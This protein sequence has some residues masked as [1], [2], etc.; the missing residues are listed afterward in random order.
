MITYEE[1]KERVRRAAGDYRTI[2]KDYVL[3][4]ATAKTSRDELVQKLQDIVSPLSLPPIQ[5][6]YNG[7]K[8]YI[9]I[10]VG[11]GEN[12]MYY[13]ISDRSATE[14]NAC[15]KLR[16]TIEDTLIRTIGRT[17]GRY[18]DELGLK[19]AQ[20]LYSY[21]I[22]VMN[23]ITQDVLTS[24]IEIGKK[25]YIDNQT[26][27]NLGHKY[28]KY[29][30]QLSLEMEAAANLWLSQVAIVPGMKLSIRDL[31]VV[32][33]SGKTEVRTVKRVADTT[34]AIYFRETT[35]VVTD[36]TRI[37][38]LESW[39]INEPEFAE[40]ERVLNLLNNIIR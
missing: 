35:S 1:A 6:Q 9:T 7:D 38:A 13:S 12:E 17:A 21:A 24:I 28:R 22:L 25:L 16:Q 8:D 26:L 5:F 32:N 10:D 30:S 23:D 37:D 34:G 3:N 2:A 40:M 18:G 15:E 36:R 31:R 4:S 14:H 11:Y 20:Q 19:G 33:T 27:S 29:C 39:F